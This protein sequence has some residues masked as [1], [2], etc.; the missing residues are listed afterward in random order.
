MEKIVWLVLGGTTLAA[1]VF[2]ANRRWALRTARWALGLLMIGGGALVNAVYLAT[3]TSFASFADAAHFAF[4]RDTWHAVVAPHQIP[5][6]TLLIIF[7]A[8]AGILVVSG[9][10]RAQAGLLGLIGMHI[11]LLG[12]GWI[13]TIWAAIM[14]PTFVLLLQA[15][16]HWARQPPRRTTAGRPGNLSWAG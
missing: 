4:I 6:I 11:G 3:G 1:A 8:A 16:R 12:F 15:E 10:T 9:G 14:L 7:E 5:F 2:A 13:F